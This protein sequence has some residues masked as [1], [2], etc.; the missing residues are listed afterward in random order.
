MVRI[1]DTVKDRAELGI[2]VALLVWI[3]CAI[4]WAAAMFIAWEFYPMAS[5]VLRLMLVAGII[6]GMLAFLFPEFAVDESPNRTGTE[7]ET[8][9][10]S[11]NA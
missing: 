2:G 4:T 1:D 9:N 8:D 10:R 5:W 7:R 11:D 6:F 3:I